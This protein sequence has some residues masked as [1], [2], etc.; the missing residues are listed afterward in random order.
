MLETIK[1]AAAWLSENIDPT[2]PRALFV[3]A[4]LIAVLL[5][6]KAFPRA[7]EAFA[8]VV[9]VPAFDAAP[10][11]VVVN[12]AWQALPGTLLGGVTLGLG[13][14]DVKTGIKGA[15]FGAL[16]ALAHEVLKAVPWIPYQGQVGKKGLPPA[17]LP[18]L[19]L[20]ALIGFSF[21]QPGIA[22]TPAQQR[23]ASADVV[24]K[25]EALAFNGA[26][27]ALLQLD[28]QE[29][30]HLDSLEHPTEVQIQAAV[31]RVARLTRARD[32]LA[33]VRRA[34]AGEFGD[35]DE[36]DKLREAVEA[37]DLVAAELEADGVK[38]PADLQRA[39]DAA[40]VVL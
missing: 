17:V 16:A 26:T 6:R 32:A 23:A 27:L 38:L 5:L 29:A 28:A 10:V 14:G 21:A 7:W 8:R 18:V 33:I 12:K 37:L 9:H 3:V 40:R 20:F 35:L 34:L 4:V 15:A 22:C 2:V 11:I 30:R 25:A 13:T 1:V 31:L 39:L 19:Y 36:R 24:A